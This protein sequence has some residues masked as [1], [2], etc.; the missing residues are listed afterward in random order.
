MLKALIVISGIGHICLAMGSLAIPKMLNWH[1]A[2]KNVPTLIRQI[3]WT[4][5]GYILSI[6]I[7]F[8]VISILFVDELL[9]GSGLANAL[10]ILIA[11]YWLS[12]ITIQFVYFDKTGV[13]AGFWYRAG[14]I[15]LVGLF[16]MFTLVY[17]I[18]AFF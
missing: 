1:A 15:I 17:G 18:A 4:Y 9:S 6:N 8:G 13:P 14:E 10:L 2:L 3:F 12:R 7:F 16:V 5:A 11:L